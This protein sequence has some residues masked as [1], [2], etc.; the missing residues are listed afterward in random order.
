[1]KRYYRRIAPLL[2]GNYILPS[3]AHCEI[4]TT[5]LLSTMRPVKPGF[6]DLPAKSKFLAA[7]KFRVLEPGIEKCNPTLL[8]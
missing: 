4:S 8:S 3:H 2:S 6:R 5:Y 1:M 7:K